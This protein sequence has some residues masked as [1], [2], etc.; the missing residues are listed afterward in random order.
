MKVVD[1]IKNDLKTDVNWNRAGRLV[2]QGATALPSASVKYAADK[3]PIIG[4]LPRY[5]YR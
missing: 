2:R 3:L 5:N 1:A 4:W